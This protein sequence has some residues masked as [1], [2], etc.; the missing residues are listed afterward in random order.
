MPT[1]HDPVQQVFESVIKD[2][3]LNLKDDELFSAISKTTTIDEVYD[4]TDKLQEEQAKKGHLRHLSKIQPYLEGLNAYAS[5][6]EVFLQAK[7]EVLALIWGPSKLI[8][9]MASVLK[10]SFDAIIDTTAEIGIV[11]PEFSV[12]AKLFDHNKQIKDILALFFKDLLQFY[13]IALKFFSLPRK[14]SSN[15]HYNTTPTNL[16]GVLGWK[17]FFESLWPRHRSKIKIVTDH[18]SRLTLLMRN[19]VRLE[20]IQEEHNARRQALEHFEQTEKHHRRQ[21]Y[22]SIKADVSP[23]TYEDKY[24]YLQGRICEGTGNWLV[25]D[26]TFAKWLDISDTSTKLLWLQGIPGAGQL[27]QSCIVS[28]I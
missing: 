8:L 2:F 4:A 3:K 13:L 12:V 18:I 26:V 19:E 10:Q 25:K 7:Q 28:L 20:H 6:I 1:V 14:F 22:E 9:Q 21:E 11:L 27:G 17:Y 16:N 5:V 15:L 23:K 24:Y